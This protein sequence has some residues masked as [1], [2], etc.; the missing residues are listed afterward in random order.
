MSSTLRILL[1]E[2]HWSVSETISHYLAKHSMAVESVDCLEA[3]LVVAAANPPDVAVLDIV[4]PERPGQMPGFNQHTGVEAA[5][6]L[7]QRYPHIGIVFYSGY[8]DRG[9]EVVQLATESQGRIVYLLKGSKPDELLGAI[10]KVASGSA[11]LDLRDG[12]QIVRRTAVDAALDTLSA[13]ERGAIELALA[14]LSTL[15]EPERRVFEVVGGCRT[16]KQAADELNL[17]VK[18]V[19]SHLEAIYEKLGLREAHPGLS[20]AMIMAKLRLIENLR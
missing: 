9:P 1:L 14:R 12:V 5:R 4:V 19:S 7:R 13:A 2:D 17:S 18:T 15:S 10:H 11:P 16:H 8:N 3:A 20:Q 6:L